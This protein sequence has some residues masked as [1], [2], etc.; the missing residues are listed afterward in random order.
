MK[1]RINTDNEQIAR[2]LTGVETDGKLMNMNDDRSVENLLKDQAK[3]AF[4]QEVEDYVSKFDKHKEYLEQY[5][6]AFKESAQ[7]LEV[8]PI[9]RYAL[10][11]PFDENPFQQ[12]KREGSII[13]DL[14][15][16]KPIYKSQESGEWEEEESFVHVGTV[17]E[18]GTKC[19][20]LKEGDVVMFPKTA[21]VPVPFYKQGL[22][23]VD[24]QRIMV[25]I[26]ENLKERFNA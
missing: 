17:M 8:M 25:V 15:G 13:T 4:N 19:E 9:Y 20:Y 26:N 12:I 5:K 23:I 1:N 10:I 3:V 24:E 6:E 16:Q 7:Q 22:V 2:V 18:V 14:G 11:Q 21:E